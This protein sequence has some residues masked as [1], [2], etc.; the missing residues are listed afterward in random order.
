MKILNCNIGAFGQI[1]NK[2]IEFHDGLNKILGENGSGKTTLAIFIKAMFY[3]IGDT[4]RM[5]LEENERKHYF[6]WGA[7]IFGGSMEFKV[8]ETSYRVERLFGQKASEDTFAL[9]DLKTGK[10]SKDFTEK[11][12][13]ELFG[14]DSEGYEETIFLSEKNLSPSALNKSVSAKLVGLDGCEGDMG[15]MDEALERL[16]R[17]RRRYN[18]KG[19]GRILETETKITEAQARICRL[20][21]RLKELPEEKK[22]LNEA[23]KRIHQ[24][25]SIIIE[26]EEKKDKA[27]LNKI[28]SIEKQK[29]SNMEALVCKSENNL[30]KSSLFFNGYIP[31]LKEIND[32]RNKFEKAKNISS[33]KSLNSANSKRED[34][35]S[36][37]KRSIIISLSV[38]VVLIVFGVLLGYLISPLLYAIC[39]LGVLYPLFTVRNK[40]A[41][42]IGEKDSSGHKSFEFY[43]EKHEKVA[44]QKEAKAFLEKYGLSPSPDSFDVLV[45]HTLEYEKLLREAKDRRGEYELILS[46]LG[47][48]GG[49]PRLESTDTVENISAKISEYKNS[50][51]N[52]QKELTLT[53]NKISEL[54]LLSEEVEE[55]NEYL[56]E[57]QTLLKED[58]ERL[59]I[60]R[61]TKD[62]LTEA[63]ENMKSKHLSRIQ[64][65]FKKYSELIST[66]SK[67]NL[68]IDSSFDITCLENGISRPRE[69]YSKGT[70][71]LFNIAARLA[72]SDSLYNADIPPLILDDPFISFDDEKISSALNLLLE[73]SKDRQIIYFACSKSRTQV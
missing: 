41:S 66:R 24:Y 72:V 47:A 16:E 54:I 11:L 32:Q 30:K 6:P 31:S 9:Y 26:L 71:E 46:E 20:S 63:Q 67:N 59:R 22:K 14:I 62:L 5:S 53:E 56:Y 48:R 44:L 40:R 8:G 39:V 15:A 27:I 43:G 50:I 7:S 29:L 65:G 60:I 69:A 51:L 33:L 37:K 4:R 3:G 49:E 25:D 28:S 57:L 2:R 45:E 55:T 36:T 17:E 38:A 23:K 19:G 18:K 68:R 34:G 73:L 42:A 1:I 12:G 64:E 10:P 13:E 61:I 35:K 52:I 21:E 58:E 70:R